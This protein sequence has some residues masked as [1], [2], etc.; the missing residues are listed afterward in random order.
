MNFED[1]DPDS[2]FEFV[3]DGVCLVEE[4]DNNIWYNIEVKDDMLLIS[5]EYLDEEDYY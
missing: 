2:L 5:Y 1:I 3:G 4:D